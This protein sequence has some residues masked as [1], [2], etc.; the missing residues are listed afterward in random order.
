MTTTFHGSE[1]Y[2]ALKQMYPLKSPCPD[3]MPPLFF[4]HFWLT[5]GNMVTKTV[6]DFLN[7]GYAPPMFNDTHV[8]LIPKN[9]DPKSI[10]DYHPISLC[11][12]IFKLASKVVANRLK[13][14]LPSII[15]DTQSTFVHGRLI[16]DNV[17]VAFEAMH[18]INQ[19]KARKKGEM[20]L[21]LEMRKAYDHVEWAY[22][23]KIME[24]LGF[25]LRWRS[26]VMKCVTTISYSFKINGKIYGFV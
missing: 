18:H 12:V 3:G 4:Q 24:N 16:T 11:N 9:K 13:K 1:V 17:L 6:L 2:S 14:V 25:N 8:V 26:L 15:S 19:K 10:F 22:L 21:N 23:D 7:F 5:I 20:A